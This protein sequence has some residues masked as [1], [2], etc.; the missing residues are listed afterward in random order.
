VKKKEMW[1][2]GGGKKEIEGGRKIDRGKEGDWKK[3]KGS[4]SGKERR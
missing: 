1:M 2:I 3:K 4:R